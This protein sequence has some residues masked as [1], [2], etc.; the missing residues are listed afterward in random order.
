MLHVLSFIAI[1][2]D[3]TLS[4]RDEILENE[5]KKVEKVDNSW[6]I[7]YSASTHVYM[8]I[9]L[10]MCV[11]GVKNWQSGIEKLFPPFSPSRPLLPPLP[12]PCYPFLPFFSLSHHSPGG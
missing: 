9:V 8:I 4:T 12:S 6:L 7:Q 2:T 1:T 10:N 11:P 3:S 5:V